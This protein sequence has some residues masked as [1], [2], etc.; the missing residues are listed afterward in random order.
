MRGETVGTLHQADLSGKL[1][2]ACDLVVVHCL[3]YRHGR[4]FDA[5]VRHAYGESVQF[6]RV[7]AAGCAFGLVHPK[8]KKGEEGIRLVDIDV[9]VSK[10]TPERMAVIQHQECGRYADHYRFETVE[11]EIAV[12][13]RDL[14]LTYHALRAQYPLLAI[15]LFIVE[16]RGQQLG[17]LIPVNPPV[18]VVGAREAQQFAVE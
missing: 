13:T 9:A 6:D 5:L 4:P 14:H 8:R 10:H 12:L 15:D 11:E 2:T 16:M 3:D 18:A 17:G 1:R 7:T